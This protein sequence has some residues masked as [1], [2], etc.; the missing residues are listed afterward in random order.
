MHPR[1]SMPWTTSERA[2]RTKSFPTPRGCNLGDAAKNEF[3]KE[4]KT[5]FSRWLGYVGLAK[6][7]Q[8]L[9]HRIYIFAYDACSCCILH[10]AYLYIYTRVIVCSVAAFSFFCDALCCDFYSVWFSQLQIKQKVVSCN[11]Q[12]Y[13]FVSLDPST[14]LFYIVFVHVFFSVFSF[15][16]KVV[17]FLPLIL[18]Y[19]CFLLS[20]HLLHVAKCSSKA[21]FVLFMWHELLFIH[22]ICTNYSEDS[23]GNEAGCRN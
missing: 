13:L 1:I 6:D 2:D 20:L 11:L 10:I 12:C 15:D 21:F 17:F 19:C 16:S 22:S 8:T 3:P 9:S 4:I 14:L 5:L 18:W 7:W 23:R